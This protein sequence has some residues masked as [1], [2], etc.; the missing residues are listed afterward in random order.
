M[1]FLQLIGLIFFATLFLVAYLFFITKT[2][3]AGKKVQNSN[4][5]DIER[6]EKAKELERLRD[7]QPQKIAEQLN[8]NE[9]FRKASLRRQE[10]LNVHPQ[11]KNREIETND[12]PEISEEHYHDR[13]FVQ[14]L[15]S[16]KFVHNSTVLQ[17]DESGISEEKKSYNDVE[18]VTK[19]FERVT[20]AFIDKNN[21][22]EYSSEAVEILQRLQ[23]QIGY[24][25]KE[26]NL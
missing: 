25:V 13:D 3:G 6:I 10:I 11:L 4:I 16:E 2:S 24:S 18:S 9:L 26:F 21:Y 7:K 12:E 19:E 8:K 5:L 20:Q 15:S 1:T 17:Q 22:E 14:P 23:E